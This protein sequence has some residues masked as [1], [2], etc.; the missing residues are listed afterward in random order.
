M[1]FGPN[2]HFGHRASLLMLHPLKGKESAMEAG[3]LKP[4]AEFCSQ[5]LF[6]KSWKSCRESP[7][8]YGAPALELL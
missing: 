5:S 7:L 3:K 8:C 2:Q 6:G 1:S 4:K